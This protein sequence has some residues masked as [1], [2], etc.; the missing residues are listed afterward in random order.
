M[1]S[2]GLLA[3]LAAV[4]LVP[5]A[6]IAQDGHHDHA[7]HDT[8]AAAADDAEDQLEHDLHGHGK[9]AD[10]PPPATALPREPIP[11]VTPA[12]RVAAFPDV[13]GHSVHDTE[14]HS[15][16][17]LDRLEAWNDDGEHGFAW[18]GTAWIGTDI[19]RAWI[20]SEGERDGSTLEAATVEVLYG[21]AIAPWWDLV[22]GVRHDFGDD[23]DQTFAAIGVMGQAPYK[24]EVEATAYVAPDGQTAAA[25]EA[26]Y[27]TLLT[28]R[29]VLQWSAEAAFFGRDDPRRGIGSG[30]DTAEAALRLRYEF[31][32]RFAPY[33]G[34]VHERAFG[35]AADYRRAFDDPARDTRLVIGLRTWF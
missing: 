28:N 5:H 11:P 25:L 14:V 2:R 19:D 10:H 3:G 8:P 1:G 7:S 24:F 4:C 30:L 32:R 29:L 16:W 15:F 6:A 13:H 21:R 26:E 18:D 20:R 33:L 22:A 12:D 34:I 17:L 27:E 9:H 35:D 23:P 31:T